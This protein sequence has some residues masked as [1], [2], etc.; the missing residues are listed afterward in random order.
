MIKNFSNFNVSEQDVSDKYVQELL[1]KIG[2]LETENQDLSDRIDELEDDAKD[3][4][5]S[6]EDKDSKIYGLEESFEKMEKQSSKFEDEIQRLEK[7]EETLNEEKKDLERKISIYEEPYKVFEDKD[8]SYQADITT[9]FHTYLDLME[10][11]PDKFGVLVRKYMR[12]RYDRLLFAMLN[13][14]WV[15]GFTGEGAGL[16][17]RYE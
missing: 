5:K 17:S 12:P 1:A 10:D 14:E 2:K 8:S 7:V 6:I 4:Q 15:D 11:Y 9:L 13:K 3:L 16:L